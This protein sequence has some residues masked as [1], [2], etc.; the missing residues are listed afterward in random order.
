MTYPMVLRVAPA[1]PPLL[2]AL[3]PVLF[4]SQFLSRL[5]LHS[6]PLQ[7]LAFLPRCLVLSLPN[8]P[9]SRVVLPILQQPPAL[10]PV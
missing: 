1:Y 10:I 3:S 2:R 6:S 7:P 8:K 9:L 4:R 5:P